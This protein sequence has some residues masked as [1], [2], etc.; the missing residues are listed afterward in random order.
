M[1]PNL[2]RKHSSKPLKLN[3]DGRLTFIIDITNKTSKAIK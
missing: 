3:L 2:L 1:L